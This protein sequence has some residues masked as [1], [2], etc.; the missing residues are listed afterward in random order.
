MWAPSNFQGSVESHHAQVDT[1][2]A[3]PDVIALQVVGGHS[4]RTLSHETA[5]HLYYHYFYHHLSTHDDLIDINQMEK[6]WKPR[7]PIDPSNMSSHI[8][9]FSIHRSKCSVPSVW[10]MATVI[11]AFHEYILPA[12]AVYSTVA[13]VF[14]R[15]TQSLMVKG[16]FTEGSRASRLHSDFDF[17]RQ[18]S[19]SRHLDHAVEKY[20]ATK[21]FIKASE[22][23]SLADQEEMVSFLVWPLAN[24]E[25]PKDD[26]RRTFSVQSTRVFG[27]AL[28]MQTIGVRIATW[29]DQDVNAQKS[30]THEVVH[31]RWPLVVH[32]G[33]KGPF[34]SGPQES[35]RGIGL[36][37]DVDLGASSPG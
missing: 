22:P 32:A 7:D 26:A 18:F 5:I 27:A 31:S 28:S 13:E 8:E 35:I 30:N 15:S 14:E 17:W 34:Q 16:T 6:Q 4:N 36:L 21:S 12:S 24:R 25:K 11:A 37:Q 19:Q 2:W 3:S 33:F 9:S 29:T 10:L 1:T 23:F 20:L